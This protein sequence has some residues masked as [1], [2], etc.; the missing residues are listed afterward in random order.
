MPNKLISIRDMLKS[1]ETAVKSGDAARAT[2]LYAAVLARAPGHSKAKRALQRLR[3][4]IAGAQGLTQADVNQVIATLNSGRF[5][6]AVRLTRG[7]I[8]RAPKEPLLYNILGMALAS[9]GKNAEAIKVFRNAVKINPSY[10]EALANLG[11]S[12]LEVD[13]V[14]DALANL[15]KAT[16]LKP[17]LA[18][19]FHNLGTAYGRDGQQDQAL[20][21]FDKALKIRPDYVNALNSKGVLL[22]DRG[23]LSEA[24]S[25]YQ[26]GLAIS[27]NSA[28]ILINLGY[29]LNQFNQEEQAA[30]YL[31]QALTITPENGDVWMRLGVLRAS[32]GDT[33]NALKALDRALVVTPDNAE[34]YLTKTALTKYRSGEPEITK[35]KALFAARKQERSHGMYLGFGLGKAL[36]DIGEFTDAFTCWSWAN[37]I[38][39]QD[40]SYSVDTDRRLFARV[41][42]AFGGRYIDAYRGYQDHECSPIFVV[43]MLRSGTTLVEQILASH[44][45]VQGAGELDFVNSYGRRNLEK[46]EQNPD[47]DFAPFA[48]EY[49]ETRARC[50]T[51]HQHIVDKLPGNFLWLGLIKSVFPKAKII[52]MRRDPRDNC[53]SVY[54]NFFEANA[55]EYGYDLKEL[56]EFYALYREIMAFWE[57]QLEGQIYHCDYEKLTAEP[58]GESRKLLE[59]CDLNWQPEVLEF[60]NAKNIVK[61]AS[62]GQIRQKINR[63]SVHA[64]QRFET[65]LAPLIKA[66]EQTGYLA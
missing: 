18:E 48:T 53:L 14:A 54:K 66:L 33:D 20:I 56:A 3:R 25:C 64:W 21:S 15:Q 30:D 61:T 63:K 42:S 26:A 39:R 36:E 29:A 23:Q 24:I 59:F 57:P 47:F 41:K 34:P 6:E 12:F 7:L 35:M 44:T 37:R 32:L 13:Q 40:F 27:P 9:S 22:K 5:E 1:A 28:D 46:I 31:Q 50:S 58:E 17:D 38:R 16:R 51:D 45:Q 62:I 4:G 43:G 65:E 10:A 52:N 8:A 19:A 55:H 49:R 11:A 2:S 60:Y